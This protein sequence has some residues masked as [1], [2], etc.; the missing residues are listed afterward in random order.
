MK[1][2]SLMIRRI[3]LFSV[4]GVLLIFFVRS[5]FFWEETPDACR[6]PIGDAL[7]VIVLTLVSYFLVLKDNENSRKKNAVLNLI[8]KIQDLLSDF[9]ELKI[10]TDAERRIARVKL[11]NISNYIEILHDELVGDSK[12]DIIVN[13]IDTLS[14][15]VLDHIDDADYL[16]KSRAEIFKLISNINTQLE[17]ICFE[18]A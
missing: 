4:M 18:V 17:R 1:K 15:L 16:G 12:I 5:I 3:I 6:L 2:T 9:W 10:N 14:S 8:A 7:E 11:T 13:D